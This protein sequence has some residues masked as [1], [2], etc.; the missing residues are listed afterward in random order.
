MRLLVDEIAAEAGDLNLG[1]V[2]GT[3]KTRVLAAAVTREIILRDID[4]LVI[5]EFACY[6]HWPLE[7]LVD[8]VSVRGDNRLIL[9]WLVA[10]EVHRHGWL[11][12]VLLLDFDFFESHWVPVNGY[13]VLHLVVIL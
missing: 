9:A 13:I 6:E 7:I 2:V 5:F 10:R 11:V 3:A 1:L 12:L 4:L 8:Q